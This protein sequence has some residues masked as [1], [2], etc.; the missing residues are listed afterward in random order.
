MIPL[1]EINELTIGFQEGKQIH[2]ALDRLN[3]KIMPG[4]TLGIVG[5]S[6]SGKS[7][8]SLAIMRLLSKQAQLTNGQIVLNLKD[9]EKS[10]ITQLSEK[11]LRKL[12]GNHIAMIF[13][14]PMTALNP[15]MR[16]GKQV[17]EV[18]LLHKNLTK[19]QAK[20]KTLQL[21]SEVKLPRPE[22]IY[23]S[24]PHQLSGGQK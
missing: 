1:L 9:K 8:T 2:L 11:E 7:L 6:G 12:R 5:E 20:E 16:C 4:E 13:Q 14:E 10:E 23:K 22:A 17:D 24:Y 15:V 3:L 21:F 19:K 18:L